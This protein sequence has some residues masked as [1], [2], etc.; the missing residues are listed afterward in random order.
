MLVLA[1]FLGNFVNYT[2]STFFSN[3]MVNVASSLN[4]AVGT[5]SQILTILRFASFIMGL[6]MGFLAVKFK[7]KSLFLVGVALYGVG[8]LGCF[9]VPNFA[10]LLFFNLFL[11]IGASMISIM[12]LTLVGEH[13]PLQQRGFAIGLVVA[14]AS[15]SQILTPQVTSIVS[16]ALGWRAVIL[17]YILPVALVVLLFSFF[18]IPSKSRQERTSSKPEYLK[19]FKQIL[20][21]KS[22]IA[23]VVGSALLYL[24]FD[25]PVYAVTFYRLHFH[26]SLSMGANFYSLASATLLLGSLVGGRLINR[27]GRKRLSVV[28]GAIQGI[29]TFLIVFVPNEYVSVAMWMGS[30]VFAGAAAAAFIGLALEQVPGFRGTMMSLNSAFRSIGLIVGLSLGGLLLNLYANNF[31]IIYAIFGISGVASGIIVLLFAKD[32]CKTSLPTPV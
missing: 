21:S 18:V 6:L 1:L 24:S 9:F 28:A 13:L 25:A 4:V 5:A 23:C 11:G 14:G 32:P 2:F 15:V 26:E 30:T 29:F 31:Q 7:S 22:A 10:S 16:N 19:A 12:M 17:L 3:A 20:T 8:A 27:I